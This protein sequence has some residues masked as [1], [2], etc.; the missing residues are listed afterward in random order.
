VAGAGDGPHEER[1]GFRALQDGA[2]DILGILSST[3]SCGA[4]ATYPTGSWVS[5]DA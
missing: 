4:R 5:I 3:L 2:E 1:D